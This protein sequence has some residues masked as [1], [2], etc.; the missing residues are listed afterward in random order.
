MKRRVRFVLIAIAFACSAQGQ[1]HFRGTVLDQ[2]KMPVEGAT[3]TILEGDRAMATD[4]EGRFS[5]EGILEDTLQV[6]ITHLAFETRTSEVFVRGARDEFIFYLVPAV[7]VLKGAE[8]IAVRA[9]DRVPIAKSLLTHDDIART[10][11][12]VDLP[13]LLDQQPS[14]VT[15]SDGGTGIGY[16]G[17]RIRGSDPTRI[18]VTING[19]P[20]NDAESATV[21]WVDLPDFASSAED[22][23][24]Q[25]GVG[26]STNGAGAFGA[27]INLRTSPVKREPSA[28]LDLS[29]GSFNTRRVNVRAGS[30]LIDDRFAFDARLSTIQSDGYI[31]R[32]TADLKSFFV[33]GAWM[34]EK[35]S[36]RAI[37]FGGH[38][39]TYQ[40][41]AGVP[42]EVIDTN[43]TFNPYT[44]DNEVD[45]Y[46]QTHYQ[47]LFDQQFGKSSL[48]NI[49]LFEVDGAGFYENYVSDV[50]A[51]IDPYLPYPIIMGDDTI[52][53]NDY[54]I[55]RWLDNTLHGANASVKT[56][57]GKHE[58]V[59]GGSFSDY[60]GEHF[61]EVIWAKFFG[62]Y[63]IRHRYYDNDARKADAN[64]FAKLTYAVNDR[65]DLYAD[66]QWRSVSYEFLGFDADLENSGTSLEK[67]QQKVGYDFFN[68]KVGIMARMCDGSRV[69]ASIA[70]AKK[71][72][73]RDDFVDSSPASRPKPE[74][75][76]DGEFGVA[77]KRE[78]FDVGVNLYY[79]H[80]VDQ[81]VLTGRLND[82]GA[83]TR[84]NVAG[85]YRAGAEVT[86]TARLSKRLN[87][88]ANATF[89]RNRIKDFVEHVD[90]WDNGG[91]EVVSYD[92]VDI[93]FS[94]SIIAGSE[95]RF[96]FID[97]ARLGEA[98]L[99]LVTKY[100][101]QQFLDNTGSAARAL[102]PYLVNDLRLNW[103]LT[104]LKGVKELAVNFT[105]RNLFSEL[106]ES[107]GWSYS[108]VQEDRRREMVGLYPQ[109]P[110][111]VMGGV[112]VG[113]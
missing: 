13:Y 70:V 45:D 79:M 28:G 101:G 48:L 86:A 50:F 39:I 93:A 58:L 49:T 90:D 65:V 67:A 108:Y 26:T 1:D 23:Q 55:R 105:V 56:T 92:E 57:F 102:D 20:L 63:P 11:I 107:N 37:V 16:T 69:Y 83:Y 99:T 40:A 71:E 47:L 66:L 73:N 19:V 91:Q 3:V 59:F 21:Y 9:G 12:G 61:G 14:V 113:F 5:F 6:S 84:E 80:Y 24:V 112:R 7:V 100:V 109:A 75:L 42:R 103:T 51:G 85:S 104:S 89:S 27:S 30:G 17:L 68:P 111:N 15:T 35:R 41:W 8:V 53:R 52:R 96:R 74:Q 64:A 77:V 4:V 72:P 54:I 18:N 62:Q 36:L 81:L 46:T 97:H 25:R 2:Q 106:Y 76:I 60:R 43:R 34:G 31:D 94:P 78:R 110:L 88:K 98:D 29:G 82:V 10:N 87:W 95:L 33:Q 38:E 22:V 32:A 44:Y